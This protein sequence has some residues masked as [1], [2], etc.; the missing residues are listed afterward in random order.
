MT[1]SAPP[2]HCAGASSAPPADR[3]LAVRVCQPEPQAAL[4]GPQSPYTIWPESS[5]DWVLTEGSFPSE[6]V[7]SGEK[8][9][10]GG[11]G[12]GGGGEGG[13]GDG[14]GGGGEGGGLGGR[15]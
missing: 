4:Q 9:S 12:E 7:L 1:A 6:V 3:Q 13:G 5:M 14:L 10:R 8:G 15:K 2:G 11:G